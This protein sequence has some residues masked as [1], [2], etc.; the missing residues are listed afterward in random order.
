ME[1]TEYRI[2]EFKTNGSFDNYLQFKDIFKI[3]KYNFLGLRFGDYIDKELW[4]FIPKN[5]N[6]RKIKCPVRL[7]GNNGQV[8]K[9]YTF[10]KNKFKNF[11]EE[12][13]NI[14]LYFINHFYF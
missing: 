2:K 1:K 7:N 11:I 12:Y 3:R 10:N 14:D 5:N 9:E 4:R 6:I 8:L 13:P